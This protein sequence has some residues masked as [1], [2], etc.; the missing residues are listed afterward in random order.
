MKWPNIVLKRHNRQRNLFEWFAK[1][2][3]D[4]FAGEETS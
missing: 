2:S 3:G 4:G 1:T